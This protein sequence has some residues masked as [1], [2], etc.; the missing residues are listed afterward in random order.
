MPLFRLYTHNGGK[1]RSVQSGPALSFAA[2]VVLLGALAASVGVGVSGWLTGLACGS[3]IG[4]LLTRAMASAQVAGLGV[5]NRVTL[6]RAVLAC[7]VAALAAQPLASPSSVRTLVGLSAV[8]LVLDALDGQVAR[9]TGTTSRFGARF[10]MEV[11]AFL[12][13]VLSAYV[14]QATAW[15]VLAMG[16]AR[17]VF[18]TARLVLPGLRGSAPPRRWCKVVA[19]VQG[20]V[21]TAVAADVLPVAAEQIALAVALAMLAESFGRE[22]WELWRAD[23][24][25]R[26]RQ[27]APVGNA[28]V[29]DG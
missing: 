10:D 22:A 14:A 12:I 1:M 17:Y 20:I 25:A 27:V 9:R 7:G 13:L 28:A 11:D 29:R 6:T 16:L 2:V 23:A 19:A 5:A 4:L 21:L 3:V 24:S 18:W 8:A 26:A 15:W